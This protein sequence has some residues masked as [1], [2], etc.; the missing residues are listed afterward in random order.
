M[1]RW[2][3]QRFQRALENTVFKAKQLSQYRVKKR[4]R[5][6]IRKR[7]TWFKICNNFFNIIDVDAKEDRI[8]TRRRDFV[9]DEI[10]VIFILIKN[11]NSH[12]LKRSQNPNPDVLID[13]MKVLTL[14]TEFFFWILKRDNSFKKN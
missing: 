8:A 12:W 3:D 2:F 10:R 4:Q 11:S 5:N 7:M 13:G 1:K 9:I 6:D 14:A